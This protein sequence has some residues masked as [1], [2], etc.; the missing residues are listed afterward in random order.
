MKKRLMVCVILILTLLVLSTAGAF[1]SSNEA[2]NV[3]YLEKQN[4]N[5]QPNGVVASVT[6]FVG[7]ILAG[8]IVDGVLIYA[9]GQSGGEWVAKVLGYHKLH[10][11][12]TWINYVNGL[13]TGGGFGGGGG[14]AWNIEYEI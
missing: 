4:N 2:L 10:P 14:G 6:I 5:I 9:T 11:E 12:Y 3:N 13:C 7:G 1:A 8:Y